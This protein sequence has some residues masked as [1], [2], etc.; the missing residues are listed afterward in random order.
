MSELEEQL[1][2]LLQAKVGEPPRQVTVRAVR[3]QAIRRR[4]IALTMTAVIAATGSIGAAVAARSGAGSLADSGGPHQVPQAGDLARVPRF[5]VVGVAGK[6]QVR[7]TATGAI[8]ALVTCPDRGRLPVSLAAQA[9]NRTYFVACQDSAGSTTI[10][11][12]RL[13]RAGQIPGLSPVPGGT[14]PGDRAGDLA[15]AA[16]GSLIAAEVTPLA[17]GSQAQIEVISPRTGSRATWG[18]EHLPG[19]VIFSGGEL[20]F[21]GNGR[22]LAVFGRARC[23][24]GD[25]AC[26]SPDEEMLA[27]S[28]AASG[29]QLSSG[30]VVFTQRQVGPP[31]Q[32][33]INDAYLSSDGSAVTLSLLGD[34][35]E[36][37]SVSVVR[38]SAATGR[39]TGRLFRLVTGNG[40]DYSF[41]STD[42]TGRSVLFNAG[43]SHGSVFGWIDDGRLI[44]LRPSGDDADSAAW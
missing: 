11:R 32:T 18:G 29:G 24:K 21:A 30:R 10:Y 22:T 25:A 39:R 1:S 17:R 34:G 41:V 14:F 43:P 36:S 27:L 15:V 13:T 38:L 19:G 9:D 37:D 2:R 42:A 12:F 8:T 35:G 31:S 5:Y 23:R 20:S 26:E 33:Y 3:G 28:P 40:F 4:V 16:D 44:P 7:S 6:A